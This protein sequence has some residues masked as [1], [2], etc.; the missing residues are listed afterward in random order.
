MSCLIIWKCYFWCICCKSPYVHVLPQ[1]DLNYKSSE[2][3]LLSKCIALKMVEAV[4]T[5][6]EKEKKDS[7]KIKIK[8]KSARWW[9]LISFWCVI[10]YSQLSRLG[11]RRLSLKFRSA[12]I[13]TNAGDWLSTWTRISILSNEFKVT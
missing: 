13:S 2:N 7:L 6:H 5:W 1:S 9:I 11:E 8:V 4:H 12:M 10:S 3:S